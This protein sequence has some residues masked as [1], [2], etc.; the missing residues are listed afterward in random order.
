[1]HGETDT[2]IPVVGED[3][4]LLVPLSDTVKLLGGITLREL[5]KRLDAGDMER[6][7]LGRRSF[8]PR[9]SIEAY[10]ERLRREAADRRGAA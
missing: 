10:V 3:V 4:A 9:A 2:N 6:V 1:M 8:V 7:K 5:Y